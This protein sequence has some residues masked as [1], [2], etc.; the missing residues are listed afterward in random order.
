MNL[1]SHSSGTI[2]Y[3]WKNWMVLFEEKIIGKFLEFKFENYIFYMLKDI[4]KVNLFGLPG[5]LTSIQFYKNV[6]EVS[7]C[8][9]SG[10]D[11]FHQLSE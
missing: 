4:I 6:S 9:S 7:R 3:I 1:Y 5:F 10:N 11:Y 8:W 2:A